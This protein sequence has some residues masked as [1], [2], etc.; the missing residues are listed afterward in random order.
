MVHPTVVFRFYR[1]AN[2]ATI[3]LDFDSDMSVLPF[4]L[5]LVWVIV[6]SIALVVRHSRKT[7]QPSRSLTNPTTSSLSGEG[8]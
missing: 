8:S 2:M 7:T 3:G 5:S 4:L 1:A 6:L